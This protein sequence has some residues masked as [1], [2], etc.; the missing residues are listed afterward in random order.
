MKFLAIATLIIQY[1]V[2]P[3]ANASI[4]EHLGSHHNLHKS[5]H[6]THNHNN[7]LIH[8]HH[9][10][11][12]ES[13]EHSKSGHSHDFV[14]LEKPFF[15]ILIK[16][17]KTP[18]FPGLIFIP[19]KIIEKLHHSEINFYS[20]YIIQAIPPPDSFRNLPLLI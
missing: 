5:H 16:E 7:D 6:H 3:L 11:E 18:H 12:D 9:N 20:Y 8:H 14:N 1:L 13:H 2:A 4:Q 10:I 15:N 19:V 17:F